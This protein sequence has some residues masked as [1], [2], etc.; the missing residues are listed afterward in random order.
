[1]KEEN[2]RPDRYTFSILLSMYARQ[3][4]LEG[5]EK[6]WAEMARAGISPDHVL[7]NTFLRLY[8]KRGDTKKAKHLLATMASA[9]LRPNNTTYNHLL[10]MYVSTGQP[11]QCQRTW[12]EMLLSPVKIKPK[13][14][15]FLL[16]YYVRLR[17]TKLVASLWGDLR[18]AG[19]APTVFSY[20]FLMDLYASLGDLGEVLRVWAALRSQHRPFARSYNILLSLYAKTGDSAAAEALFREFLVLGFTP[21]L[22]TY[23]AM[24]ALYANKEDTQKAEEM[25]QRLFWSGISPDPLSYQ[26]LF[27]LYSKTGN[28]SKAEKLLQE[29]IQKGI[30]PSVKSYGYLVDLYAK[31]GNIQQGIYIHNLIRKDYV[32]TPDSG[33]VDYCFIADGLIRLYSSCGDVQR[34]RQVFDDA[35]EEKGLWEEVLWRAVIEAYALHG[36]GK[37]ALELFERFCEQGGKPDGALFN[38]LLTA[39]NNALLPDKALEYL[40][41]MQEQYGIPPS[42]GSHNCVV[43]ALGRAGRVEEAEAY[44]QNMKEKD[45][46]TWRSLLAACRLHGDTERAKRVA[47]SLLDLLPKDG[48]E[49][50]PKKV[51]PSCWMY[52]GGN[53]YQF[54]VG[55]LEHPKMEEIRRKVEEL[56]Q[57]ITVAGWVP[58]RWEK[59]EEMLENELCGHT[60]K[61]AIGFGLL[62]EEVGAKR[63]IV[64]FK[65]VG[66]CGDCHE[67]AKWISKVTQCSIKVRDSHRWHHF[68]DGQC[69]CQCCNFK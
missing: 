9:G 46:T 66:V 45:Q 50:G 56:Y 36:C 40:K 52:S 60:D 10:S 42:V 20:T 25:W 34:A 11:E 68:Q 21:G 12:K 65:N 31:R 62:E 58:W 27:S 7:Y 64:V 2:I 24:I 51:V 4:D 1:M 37:E 19:L 14:F 13:T 8:T 41:R 54:V 57:R 44:A 59:E 26:S 29:M 5:S 23:R 53:V 18:A 16:A 30:R 63:E 28:T 6:V 55:E 15:D 33:A 69:S 48:K 17:D 61:F 22:H 43:D 38:A 35:L 67:A 39:C 32:W 47:Q 3:E 49:D